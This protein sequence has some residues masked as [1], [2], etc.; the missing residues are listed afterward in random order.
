MPEITY[1][2]VKPLITG[3]ET[4]GRTVRVAFTC[5]VSGA[6][7]E[8]SYTLPRDNSTSSQIATRAKRSFFNQVRWSIARSVRRALGYGFVGRIVG[9]VISGAVDG[10]ARDAANSTSVSK[11]EEQTAAVEAFKRIA[12]QWAWDDRNSRWITTQAARDTLSAFDQ[13]IAAAPIAAAYD[14][15][16]AARMLVEVSSADG[17]ITRDEEAFLLEFLDPEVGTPQDL[18]QRPP[19]SDAELNE[20]SGGAVR[21]T[22][23]ML[24]W[25]LALCDEDLAESETER[26]GAY[27]RGLR[28]NP[29]QADAAKERAQLHI[30]DQVLDRIVHFGG[31]LDARA[32]EQVQSAAARLGMSAAQAEVA[33]ARFQKRR[34]MF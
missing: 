32:R 34:G 24:A 27:A 16:V 13:Q 20:T 25:A 30:L 22:L 15:S 26:L 1:E 6:T 23:L 4:Q 14:R 5:P 2:N 10:V 9:D 31:A 29:R 33:E 17:R 3:V 19:L 18:A 7:L 28:L 8:S 12:R 21:E 11:D